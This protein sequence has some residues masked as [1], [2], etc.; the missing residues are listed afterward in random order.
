MANK[1]ISSVC[2]L[3]FFL[4]YIH[5]QEDTFYSRRTNLDLILADQNTWYFEENDSLGRARTGLTW[6]G[7]H[8]TSEIFWT[9]TGNNT[10]PTSKKEK[11]STGEYT[12]D[13]DENGNIIRHTQMDLEQKIVKRTEK[14]WDKN[15]LLVYQKDEADDSVIE[16]FYTYDDSLAMIEIKNYKNNQLTR[17]VQLQ[18]KDHWTE[19]IFKEGIVVYSAIFED[20]TKTLQK[21]F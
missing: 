13:Y 10:I 1:K 19:L 7:D 12:T 11:S 21:E 6:K 17:I 2:I 4:F 14:K 20:G 9:Y 3:F 8:I 5:S 18:D 15:K 16:S